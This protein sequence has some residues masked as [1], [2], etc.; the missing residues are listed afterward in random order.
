MPIRLRA[1]LAVLALGVPVAQAGRE[2]R[3]PRRDQPPALGEVVT[4]TFAWCGPGDDVCQCFEPLDCVGDK[5]STMQSH[6]DSMKEL[7]AGKKKGT[8]FVCH[9]A[10]EGT[11]GPWRYIYCDL[12]IQGT[13][14]RFFNE[15]GR[16]AAAY[17]TSDYGEF[18]GGLA[19][20][21]YMGQI[22][23]CQPLARTRVIYGKGRTPVAPA[24]R[25]WPTR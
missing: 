25:G 21:K 15:E 8:T 3:A 4:K 10:E 1:V 6:L 5:C 18:C 2:P 20:R 19:R 22:P 16:L 23:A 7:L 24:S 14:L 13:R 17:W 11:C 12:G 9:Y